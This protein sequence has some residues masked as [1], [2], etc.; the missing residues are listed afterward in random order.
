MAD[1]KIFLLF[2]NFMLSALMNFVYD[3]ILLEHNQYKPLLMVLPYLFSRFFLWKATQKL[4]NYWNLLL[5]AILINEILCLIY[6]VVCDR[7]CWS[8]FSNCASILFMNCFLIHTISH[9][10][11]LQ[12]CRFYVRNVQCKTVTF[13]PFYH[14]LSTIVIL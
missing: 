12:V 7:W 13:A 2:D 14:E 5:Q 3:K 6:S 8:A 9:S 11:R 1:W 4:N 10:D